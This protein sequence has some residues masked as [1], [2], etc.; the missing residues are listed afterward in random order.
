[1]YIYKYELRTLTELELPIGS[2]VLYIGSQG[3][4]ENEETYERPF[5]WVLC[6]PE[7]EKETRTFLEMYTGQEFDEIGKSYIG[8]I[9]Y[10]SGLVYHYFEIIKE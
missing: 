5:I 6:D 9:Q 1:V 4:E 2:K 7:R 3:K 10:S 8:S